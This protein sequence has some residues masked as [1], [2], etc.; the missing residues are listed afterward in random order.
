MKH[1]AL[2]EHTHVPAQ[3]QS[4]QPDVVSLAV[5]DHAEAETVGD[6]HCV[7]TP[8]GN[9]LVERSQVARKLAECK[10]ALSGESLFIDELLKV[11]W[12]GSA[13]RRSRGLVCEGPPWPMTKISV[14]PCI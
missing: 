8:T 11:Q 4:M 2:D 13:A 1:A 7:G 9:L 12:A 6:Q 10:E 3:E 5:S 14:P